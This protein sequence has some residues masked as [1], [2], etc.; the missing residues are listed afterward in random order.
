[1]RRT[2]RVKRN[3]CPANHRDADRKSKNR[4]VLDFEI[5]E[6]RVPASEQIGGGLAIS[7]LAYAGSLAGRL[8]SPASVE[9]MQPVRVVAQEPSRNQR[10]SLLWWRATPPNASPSTTDTPGFGKTPTQ[11][12]PRSAEPPIAWPGDNL[13]AQPFDD[14][15]REFFDLLGSSI[16]QREG[17]MAR[18]TNLSESGA[19]TGRGD[20]LLNQSAPAGA[21]TPFGGGLGIASA[22]TPPVVD[23][24]GPGS[25]GLGGSLPTASTDGFLSQPVGHASA[26]GSTSANGTG[27]VAVADQPPP[28]PDGG[29]KKKKDSYNILDADYGTVVTPGVPDR[30]LSG[31]AMDLRQQV[32]GLTASS[33]SWTLDPNH[34]SDFTNV[35]G[36][37]SYRLQFTWASFTGAAH[38]DTVIAKYTDSTNQQHSLTVTFDVDS[39]SSPAS[40]SPPSLTYSTWP[41]VEIPDALAG[42]QA[43]VDSQ[44]YSLGLATGALLINHG[45]PAY[46]P[47]VPPVVLTYNSTA[48]DRMPIFIDHYELNPSQSVPA[49]VSAQLKITDGNGNTVFSG[50]T[51]SYTTGSGGATYNP[52]DIMEIPLQATMPS[53]QATGEYLY[54]I[55]V[56]GN[57]T[58]TVSGQFS[59]VNLQSSVFGDGWSLAGLEHEYQISPVGSISQG[60]IVDQGGGLSLWYAWNGTSYNAPQPNDFSSLSADGTVRT[61]PDGT[62]INFDSA[63]NYREISLTQPN[64]NLFTYAYD[65]SGNLL[66]ITDFDNNVVTLTYASGKVSSIAEP[67]YTMSL[68]YNGSGQLTSITDPAPGG[69]ATTPVTTIGYA[70]TTV[71]RITTFED[72]NSNTTTF[73]YNTAGR[74]FSLQRPDSVSEHLTALQVQGLSTATLAVEDVAQYTDGRSKLWNTRLD[75]LGYGLP[76]QEQDPLNDMTITYRDKDKRTIKVAS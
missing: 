12:Q 69:G 1:M 46:N 65:G 5:L 74:V 62:K 7:A 16:G 3:P 33:Y 24:A 23:L 73:T 18:M 42:D 58:T 41:T 32:A 35:S 15:T 68:G 55:T 19:A 22:A 25:P 45:M 20:A 56:T 67:A 34:L 17:N 31:V 4:R 63:N 43:T 60:A 52:G 26:D 13:S 71:D 72:P 21:G 38:T 14:L 48:A 8:A 61:L 37:S 49:T 6:T 27:T 75:W 70:S 11:A 54:S 39:S 47:G 51:V 36:Q 2:P 29:G 40:S 44:Y 57:S 28:P 64:G 30:Q 66:T 10:I 59:F 76:T 9:Q 50:T 53:T